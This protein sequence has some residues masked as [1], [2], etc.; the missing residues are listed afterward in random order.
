MSPFEGEG[1]VFQ[2]LGGF[3]QGRAGGVEAQA[4]GQPVKQR[5]PVE[6]GLEGGEAPADRRLAQPSAR[7]AARREP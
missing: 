5:R 1:G 3:K 6:G 4:L 7:P 2:L